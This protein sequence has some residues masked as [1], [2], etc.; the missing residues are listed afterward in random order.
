MLVLQVFVKR[1]K[2]YL[3]INLGGHRTHHVTKSRKYLDQMGGIIPGNID[4]F[5]V[6]M[7]F[8]PNRLNVLF[9]V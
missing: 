3:P 1:I 7:I 9:A 2:T 5:L 6:A 8:S 4:S